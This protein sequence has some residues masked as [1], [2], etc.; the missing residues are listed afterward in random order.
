MESVTRR[1][2]EGPNKPIEADA[3]RTRG[4]SAT[5]SATSMR[6][7]P[8]ILIVGMLAGCLNAGQLSGT[9]A[10]PFER[11]SKTVPTVEEAA[12]YLI[13]NDAI[14]A[15]RTAYWRSPD[16]KAFAGSEGGAW[17][18]SGGMTRDQRVR[19][20]AWQYCQG[21]VQENDPPCRVVN[22]D[23]AWQSQFKLQ[24]FEDLDP[25][26]PVSELSERERARYCDWVSH[27]MKTVL[28]DSESCGTDLKAV[29]SPTLPCTVR[30]KA[31]LTCT[32]TVGQ[33]RACTLSM[34]EVVAK[35]WCELLQGQAEACASDLFQLSA[36][37]N[38]IQTCVR[39]PVGVA[40]HP[41]PSADADTAEQQ[42]RS[43][44]Q[45]NARGSR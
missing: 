11:A 6:S 19:D 45:N 31:A 28:P 22:I 36:C 15:F 4:S 13:G 29:A 30:A 9:H 34:F 23:G 21:H 8:I 20:L 5:R 42:R 32:A 17:G 38:L 12:Q 24:T 44:A 39:A 37:E 14:E 41:A 26:R 43:D 33:I 40:C 18:W 16:H 10:P 3:K 25:Q 27:L 7:V 1:A 2:H 35:H